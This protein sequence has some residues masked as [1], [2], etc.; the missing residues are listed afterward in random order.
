MLESLKGLFRPK[1]KAE[2]K[3]PRST[4]VTVGEGAGA[5]TIDVGSADVAEA[6]DKVMKSG[7]GVYIPDTQIKSGAKKPKIVSD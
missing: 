4:T 3:V 5:A 1:R 6:I 2:T 7:E